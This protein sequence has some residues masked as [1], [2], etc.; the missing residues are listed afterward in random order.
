MNWPVNSDCET[1]HI[2]STSFKTEKTYDK[3]TIDGIEYSG[4]R[5]VNQVL[6][7]NF[8]V[9]YESDYSGTDEGFILN[10][11][12][13]QWGE[14][15]QASDW[16]CNQEKRPIQNGTETIGRLKYKINNSSCG[17]FIRN[18]L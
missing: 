9:Y 1:V 17:K 16:T 4:E 12:C 13:T 2:L 7:N 11:S 8:T 6:P 3:L 14:W 5:K 15:T 18:K 10:W